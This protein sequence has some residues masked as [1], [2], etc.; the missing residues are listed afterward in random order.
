MLRFVLFLTLFCVL[1]CSKEPPPTAPAGKATDDDCALC[2]FLGLLEDQSDGDTASD[3]SSVSSSSGSSPSDGVFIPDTALRTYI[4]KELNKN[5]GEMITQ[6]DMNTLETLLIGSH[7]EIETLRGLEVAKNL[8]TLRVKHNAISDLTPLANLVNLRY[9]YLDDNQISDLTPLANLVNLRYLYLDDNQISDLTPL[10]NLA[11]LQIL[12]LVN[13]Q[14][15][16]LAPL[17]NLVNLFYLYFDSNQV[18]DL[19]PTNLSKL[20]RIYFDWNNVS[21]VSPLTSLPGK[22]YMPGAILCEA[23]LNEHILTLNKRYVHVVLSIHLW[24]RKVPSILI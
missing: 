17:A 11:D 21:D 1:S 7:L 24:I 23:S 14:I 20:Q 18:S 9:L 13:N 19:T 8:T 5:P 6:A 15:S 12:Y 22:K 2:D 3:S 4:E 10:A 16:D